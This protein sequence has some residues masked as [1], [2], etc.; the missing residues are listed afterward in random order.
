MKKNLTELVMIL[1]ASGSMWGLTNDT[2]GGFNSLL[3]SQKEEDGEATFTAVKFNDR[4]EYMYDRVD[5]NDVEDLTRKQYYASGTTALLDALGTTIDYIGEKLS[6][7]PEEDRPSK[8]I[9]AVITD[10]QE[11]ASRE[12]TYSVIKEKI[13]HQREKYNWEFMFIG[14]N[15][16]AIGESEK[17][18]MDSRFA[19]NYTASSVGTQAVY[20]GLSKA[21][22]CMRDASFNIDDEDCMCEMS[23]CLDEICIDSNDAAENIFSKDTLSLDDIDENLPD[24][25]DD[26]DIDDLDIDDKFDMDCEFFDNINRGIEAEEEE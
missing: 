4:M 18:G 5:I 19:R 25:I 24:D 15:I 16:D 26:L 17:L 14:A 12:Y 23:A 9:F 8:V 10:G 2:I 21:M 20:G 6:N 3:N 1:D 11:N 13:Q 22:S 7:T